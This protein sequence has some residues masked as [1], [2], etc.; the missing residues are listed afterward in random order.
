MNAAESKFR[1]T[2]LD[3]ITRVVKCNFDVWFVR[4]SGGQENADTYLPD[5]LHFEGV[6]DTTY[7]RF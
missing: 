4:T 3:T 7:L 5:T 2:E 1:I 6:I